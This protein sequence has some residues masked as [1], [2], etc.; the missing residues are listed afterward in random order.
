MI[1]PVR[2]M[3]F[4]DSICV[5]QYVSIHRGWVTRTSS[6][7]YELG[8][9]YAKPI[10]VTNAS[11]NGRT[12][13][14][15]LENM[16]YEVQSP[17]ADILIVQFGMN[18]CN[19]WKSD[20]GMPR[21]SKKVFWANLHEIID[22]A[23][24][25]G[26]QKIFLNS[27]HPTGRNDEILPHTNLTY[28]QSNEQY[29]AIIRKVASER[30]DNVSLNEIETIFK[31]RTGDDKDKINELLM[32]EPDLLHLSEK[33]HDLYYESVYPRIETAVLTLLKKRY[34]ITK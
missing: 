21:V 23:L 33:G 1:Q 34:G 16:A 22:R 7:L 10:V 27:N 29:N 6:S 11:Q 14:Q 5:G 2:V 24:A 32:P 28:Q 12:T 19:Y 26:V 18:D 30:S 17:G 20:R 8:E 9:R 15:A 13:R 3:F 31:K 4:G 25:C